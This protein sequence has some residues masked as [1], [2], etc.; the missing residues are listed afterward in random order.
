MYNQYKGIEY[1]R[2]LSPL[3]NLWKKFLWDMKHMEHMNLYRDQRSVWNIFRSHGK[4]FNKYVNNTITIK[5]WKNFQKLDNN[6]IVDP[7]YIYIYIYIYIWVY[8]KAVY[9]FPV[10][11]DASVASPA[12]SHKFSNTHHLPSF[13][14]LRGFPCFL[15]PD[16]VHLKIV[17]NIRGSLFCSILIRWS[18]QFNFLLFQFCSI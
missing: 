8:T 3:N 6:I 4:F 18:F 15:F 16:G 17:S 9:L 13:H 14:D 12:V 7:I 11:I 5:Q 1:K 2:K 10:S